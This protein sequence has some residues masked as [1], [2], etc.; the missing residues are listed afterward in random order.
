MNLGDDDSQSYPLDR[1]QHSTSRTI[2]LPTPF[3]FKQIRSSDFIKV[4]SSI[5]F[6]NSAF[7]LSIDLFQHISDFSMVQIPSNSDFIKT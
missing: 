5:P 4:D 7:E 3:R 6:R 1:A 2:Q